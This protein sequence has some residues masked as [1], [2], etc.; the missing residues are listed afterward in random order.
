MLFVV[1]TLILNLGVKSMRSRSTFSIWGTSQWEVFFFNWMTSQRTS[2]SNSLW[3]VK[4][5]LFIYPVVICL[6]WFS[7][8]CQLF[9]SGMISCLWGSNWSCKTNREKG[10]RTMAKMEECKLFVRHTLTSALILL[11]GLNFVKI[12]AIWFKFS[13]FR[14]LIAASIFP[15]IHA[16]R[17]LFSPGLILELWYILVWRQRME[18]RIL[19][20]EHTVPSVESTMQC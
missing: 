6:F 9:L 20:A 12:K 2:Q 1:G 7:T 19:H 18:R 13:G 5:W 16:P 15:D 8:S 10:Y 3:L 17:I 11:S 14:G 4:D